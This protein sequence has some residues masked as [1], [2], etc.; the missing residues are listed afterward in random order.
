[1]LHPATH[2][3]SVQPTA[4]YLY[5]STGVRYTTSRQLEQEFAARSADRIVLVSSPTVTIS[6]TSNTAPLWIGV[7]YQNAPKTVFIA[8]LGR[9]S[10]RLIAAMP[11]SVEPAGAQV[12]AY[13]YDLEELAVG[14]TEAEAISEI[15]ASIA[16]AYVLLKREQANL[17]SLQQKHWRYLAGIVREEPV[18]R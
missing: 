13:S 16:D 6:S 2:W 3:S 5:A 12:L 7:D 9:A 8:D 1:M 18:V 4:S 10:L 17:G 11:I 15:K 14:E